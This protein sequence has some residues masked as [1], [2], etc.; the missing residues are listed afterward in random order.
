MHTRP[1]LA[2][3]P[4]G[5]LAA[6]VVAFLALASAA[7]AARRAPNDAPRPDGSGWVSPRFRDHPLVGKVWRPRDGAFSTEAELTAA[8]VRGRF[9]L[10]GETHDNAD[11]HLVQARLVRAIAAAGR[12]P[13]LALEMLDVDRQPEVDAALARA[14]GDSLALA[15][16]VR[17]NETGWPTFGLYRPVVEAGLA[18]GMPVVA[19]N[20]PRREARALFMKGPAA[21]PEPVRARLEKAGPFPDDVLRALRKEMGESHC[22]ELPDSMV[23]P[24][25]AAQKAKDAQL[26]ERLVAY[27]HGQ[28]SVLVAGRG[29]VRADV[30]VPMFLRADTRADDIVAVGIVEVSADANRPEDYGAE[31]GAKTLPFDWV[32]FTPAAERED[33]CVKFREDHEK[34]RAAHKPAPAPVAPPPASQAPA[35][36]PAQ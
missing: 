31:Y 12:R 11:H 26:A 15:S 13:A 34:R 21:L 4:R 10:L 35:A 1:A 27:D 30:G 23:E 29:H 8:V 6:L 32:L 14:P 5:G 3:R 2:P 9:V 22:G 20:L 17:W 7:C 16:A 33:P 19:A 24:M 28:G 36:P 18:G 25:V